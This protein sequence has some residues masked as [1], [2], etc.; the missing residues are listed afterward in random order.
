VTGKLDAGTVREIFAVPFDPDGKWTDREVAAV[1]EELPAGDAE[2]VVV[3]NHVRPDLDPA[4][5]AEGF[6]AMR[7]VFHGL[8][9]FRAF[10]DRADNPRLERCDCG[11]H[12]SLAVHYRIRRSLLGLAAI[13]ETAIHD[14]DD[15]VAAS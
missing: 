9:G 5:R 12:P 3:H 13:V 1:Y 8:N 6:T 10:L 2:V 11:W 4:W 15:D 14:A 7:E